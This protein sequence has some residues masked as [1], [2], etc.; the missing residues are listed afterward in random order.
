ML[1]VELSAAAAEKAPSSTDQLMLFEQP[2]L[3]GDWYLINP[4]PEQ[5]SEDFLAVKLTLA[6]NY[7]FAI[8]IEKKNHK[9]DRWSGEF[10]I[11]KNKIVLGVNSPTPQVYEYEENHN[12]LKLNGVIFTKFLTNKLAGSWSSV[13]VSGDG[14]AA[15]QIEKIEL[16][17]QPDFIFSFKAIDA[18]GEEIVQQ[19]IFFT[20]RDNLILLFEDGEQET[21]FKLKQNQLTIQD[22]NGEM[23]AVLNRVY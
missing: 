16:I 19:G 3:L 23:Y 8:D 2:F 11:D 18:E 10:A 22:R 7:Q 12:I 13:V 21:T 20:E 14:M 9:V 4:L 15:N 17:L 6:S 1:S 5:S